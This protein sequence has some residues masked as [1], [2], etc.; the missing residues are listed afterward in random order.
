MAFTLGNVDYSITASAAAALS[1]GTSSI[2]ILKASVCNTDSSPRTVNIYRVTSPAS[3]GATNELVKTLTIG[4]G[5]TEVLPIS[6][7]TLTAGQSIQALASV[8]AVCVL[9][10]GYAVQG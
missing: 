9:S 3:A 7:Q 6:G 2:L 4:V 5:A 1:A 10:I 8:A